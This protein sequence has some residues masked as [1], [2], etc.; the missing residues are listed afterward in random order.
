[1]LVK[2]ALEGKTDACA[3][4]MGPNVCEFSGPE[5]Y[6]RRYHRHGNKRNQYWDW[7]TSEGIS[8]TGN[9]ASPWQ[10]QLAVAE[11]GDRHEL[12]PYIEWIFGS[13]QSAVISKVNL[14]QMGMNV[15]FCDCY[16]HVIWRVH[17][18]LWKNWN[19][20]YLI[21]S[22][23]ISSIWHYELTVTRPDEIPTSAKSSGWCHLQWYCIG[24]KS[25]GWESALN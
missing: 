22:E 15:L 4:F 5:Y 21:K 24:H 3:Y 1:M 16:D 7:S 18:D 11:T 10:R 20:R 8:G 23:R 2:R 9:A 6:C 13:F 12:H 19:A 25:S 14:L 17:I